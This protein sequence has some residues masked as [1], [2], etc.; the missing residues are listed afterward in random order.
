MK[1][2]L[3]LVALTVLAMPLESLGFE[4]RPQDLK[5][6]SQKMLEYQ[7][8]SAPVAADDN[9]ILD[10]QAGATSAAAVTV[11]SF[12]AQPDVARN[13][14]V[15]PTGTTNDVAAGNVVVNGTNIRGQAISETFAFLA[16]ATGAVTGT[17]AFKTVTSIV[18]PGEDSPFGAT[19]DVGWGNKLGLDKCMDSAGF[20]VKAFIS[21]TAETVTVTSSATAIESNGVT[22]TNVPNAARV[23]ELLFIQNFRCNQ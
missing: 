12:L 6:P 1:Q 4:R 20:M 8:I 2:L 23:Y 22:P 14:V 15:T 21:G 7:S 3:L 16:N 5:L 9:G 10:D 17:K 13:I 18:F 19:W 11:S